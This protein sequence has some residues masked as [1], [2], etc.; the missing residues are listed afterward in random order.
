MKKICP[1]FTLIELLIA[2]SITAILFSIGTVQYMKFNRQQ[3]LTQAILELKTNLTNAQSMAL[4]GKKKCVGTFDGILVE[5]SGGESYTLSSSCNDKAAPLVQ[6][7]ETHR[8]PQGIT[9]T[10]G[11]A[12]ILFKTLTGGTDKT[13]EERITLT[14]SGI[15]SGSITVTTSG[16]IDLVLD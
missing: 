10:G 11:P 14:F 1:G 12:D 6:I 5:F 9:K 4:S 2:I 3:I 8:F 7:G 13:S 16:K 15:V